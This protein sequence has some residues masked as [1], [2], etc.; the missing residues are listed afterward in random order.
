[1][2]LYELLVGRRRGHVPGADP[3]ARRP[4]EHID[5]I[6]E[7]AMDRLDGR[8]P[9]CQDMLNDIQT[10]FSGDIFDK[11]VGIGFRNARRRRRPDCDPGLWVYIAK[12]QQKADL[13]ETAVTED[14]AVRR[15]LASSNPPPDRATIDK[16]TESQRCST[17][18]AARS[19][20]GGCT[21]GSR[22]PSSRSRSRRSRRSQP[23]SIASSPNTLHLESRQAGGQGH[24]VQAD[25]ACAFRQALCTE[26]AEKACKGPA[27]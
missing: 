25:D 19:R 7:V 2:L 13:M 21:G 23:T 8:Y 3:V 22:P 18:R 24:V 20:W 27:N 6:V 5:D 15:M 14:D 1:V 26:E 11:Q 16:M 9:T 10:S 17:S 12:F 4:S